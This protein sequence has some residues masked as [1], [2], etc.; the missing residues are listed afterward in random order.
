M[1]NCS[2][3]Q[4][5]IPMFKKKLHVLV[6]YLHSTQISTVCILNKHVKCNEYNKCL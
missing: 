6:F 1:D 5:V 4:D 2:L 3:I